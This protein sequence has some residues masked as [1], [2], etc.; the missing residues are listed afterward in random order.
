MGFFEHSN[1]LG[2]FLLTRDGQ[3]QR[4]LRRVG[5]QCWKISCRGCFGRRVTQVS[6]WK[7]CPSCWGPSA[8]LQHN[9]DASVLWLAH[10][11]RNRYKWSALAE[12]LNRYGLARYAQAHK[13]NRHG[14]GT[15]D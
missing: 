8:L 11:V 9:F 4:E 10:A 2:R 6:L 12:A 1:D 13:F 15:A 14:L 5:C 7:F 3:L